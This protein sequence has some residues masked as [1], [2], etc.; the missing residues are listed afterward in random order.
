MKAILLALSLTST[1]ALAETATLSIEGM[2][3]SGC[4]DMITSKVCKNDEIAKTAE[5]CEVKIL[6]E[7]KQIGQLV[8]VTKKDAHVNMDA[9][10]AGVKAAGDE[11]KIAKVDIKEM[12]V[13]D[14]ATEGKLD[15]VNSVTETT[16]TTVEKSTTNQAGKTTKE[17]KKTKKIVRKKADKTTTTTNETKTETK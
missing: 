12:I 4:K 7:K 2:H 13:K 1:M 16:T 6:D 9:I 15:P 11:Y 5:T 8:I 3:C 14:L 17:I 10:K